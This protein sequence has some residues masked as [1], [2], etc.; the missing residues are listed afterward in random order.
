MRLVCGRS[1]ASVEI[2]YAPARESALILGL[3]AEED[4]EIPVNCRIPVEL[5][6]LQCINFVHIQRRHD[7]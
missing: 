6:V 4:D 5:E 1:G 3:E 2:G 7:A